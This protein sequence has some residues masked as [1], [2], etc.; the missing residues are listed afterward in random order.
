MKSKKDILFSEKK[1][2]VPLNFIS[3]QSKVTSEIWREFRYKNST[4]P[5]QDAQVFFFPPDEKA[6]KKH[7]TV[8]YKNKQND[9]G[10]E[11]K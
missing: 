7:L 1:K 6:R 9:L 5:A 3:L 10:K 4:K 8:C 2:S 11:S